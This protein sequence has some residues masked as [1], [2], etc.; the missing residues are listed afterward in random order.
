MKSIPPTF[1]PINY[2]STKLTKRLHFLCTKIDSNEGKKKERKKIGGD[3]KKVP[4][5]NLPLTREQT[6]R[7]KG[8]EK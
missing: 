1:R 4:F 7:K 5:I 8:K 2:K 3:E 6:K